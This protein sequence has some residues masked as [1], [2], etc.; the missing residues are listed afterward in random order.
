MWYLDKD[1]CAIIQTQFQPNNNL[2]YF[3][4]N[5][6]LNLENQNEF[7]KC[8]FWA[9]FLP[10]W[11]EIITEVWVTKRFEIFFG[12]FEYKFVKVWHEMLIFSGKCDICG[13]SLNNGGWGNS[14]ASARKTESDR[15]LNFVLT[16]QEYMCHYL[17]KVSASWRKPIF[18]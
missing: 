3:T 2:Q 7:Q 12:H 18:Y 13:N 11:A 4:K 9:F 14:R 6:Y 17:C 16:N 15:I 5:F 1:I 10:K 8:N